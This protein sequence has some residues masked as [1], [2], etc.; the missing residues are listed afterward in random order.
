MFCR[1]RVFDF[2]TKPRAYLMYNRCESQN[3]ANDCQRAEVDE[4]DEVDVLYRMIEL[5][6]RGH[7]PEVLKSYDW[8]LNEA[9]K[10]LGIQIGESRVPKKLMERRSL[11]KSAFVHKKH[12]AQYEIRTHFRIFQLKH[13]TGSTAD[14]YIEYAERN[15]PE[16]VAMK[17]TKHAIER[18]PEYR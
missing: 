6:T 15:L 2:L 3:V 16:G 8:F 12:F 13:L 10:Q 18:L 1:K 17:V 7:E 14:T 9:A 5:E 11:L 4:M